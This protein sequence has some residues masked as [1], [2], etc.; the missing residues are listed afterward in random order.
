MELL[1]TTEEELLASVGIS[2]LLGKDESKEIEQ[3]DSNI[4][5]L[6]Q[7]NTFDPVEESEDIRE[8]QITSREIYYK[9]ARRNHK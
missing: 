9:L 2:C 3:L 8:L 4:D 1:K 7:E 5:S 6:E